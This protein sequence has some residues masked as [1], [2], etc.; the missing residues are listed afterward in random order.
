M[1]QKNSILKNADINGLES[2]LEKVIPKAF[3]N[4]IVAEC[5]SLQV[6]NIDSINPKGRGFSRVRF[7]R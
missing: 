2:C 4:G 6:V 5:F 7:F 1:N 3:T